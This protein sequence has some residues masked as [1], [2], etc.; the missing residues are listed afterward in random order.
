MLAGNAVQWDA[1]Q[2]VEESRKG[3]LMFL[4]AGADDIGL[5]SVLG[6]LLVEVALESW[7]WC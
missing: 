6:E 2:W 7:C 3:V 1:G 4:W 5:Q